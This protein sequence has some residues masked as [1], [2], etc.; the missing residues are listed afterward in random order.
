MVVNRKGISR[1]MRNNH[2]LT[3]KHA[4]LVYLEGC[5]QVCPKIVLMVQKSGEKT[6]LGCS[7]N[8]SQMKGFQ[9]PTKKM[10]G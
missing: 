10:V 3:H 5:Y 7:E 9:L 8:P 4:V 1:K 2:F 6:H